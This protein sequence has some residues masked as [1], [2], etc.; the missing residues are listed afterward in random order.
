MRPQS[1]FHEKPESKRENDTVSY[2]T[3]YIKHKCSEA[4]RR[5]YPLLL[6]RIQGRLH[7]KSRIA[8]IQNET[9]MW[10]MNCDATFMFMMSTENLSSE[11]SG[12]N[13]NAPLSFENHL[14]RKKSDD[15]AP[16]IKPSNIYGIAVKL[17][18]KKTA[19]A[20]AILIRDQRKTSR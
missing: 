2:G 12:M 11:K 20:A 1:V 15:V 14:Y 9:D 5:G 8:A 4:E 10:V 17:N 18:T 6:M 13:G 19:N 7:G 3:T 16:R